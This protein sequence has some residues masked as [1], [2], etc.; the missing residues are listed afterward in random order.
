MSWRS[1]EVINKLSCLPTTSCTGQHAHG[2]CRILP[3]LSLDRGRNHYGL[4]EGILCP[5]EIILI[6][7]F[8]VV[9]TAQTQCDAF[10]WHAP[11]SYC[12]YQNLTCNPCFCC[13]SVLFKFKF[14]K[15]PTKYYEEM[16]IMC[17]GGLTIRSWK[18]KG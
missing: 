5:M 6:T 7:G 2:R 12:T 10:Y 1:G 17:R 11:C 4:H 13:F 9:F 16:Y 3:K 8:E 14:K 18:L 15:K